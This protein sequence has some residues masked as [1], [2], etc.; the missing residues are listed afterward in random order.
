MSDIV[1]NAVTTPPQRPVLTVSTSVDARGRNHARRTSRSDCAVVHVASGAETGAAVRFREDHRELAARGVGVED[2]ALVDDPVV[3][4]G[5]S[6]EVGRVREDARQI[7]EGVLRRS[8]E[9][10]RND[11]LCHDRDWITS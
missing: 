9:T 6:I 7:R 5:I 8:S 4:G 11:W 2:A 1:M 10:V 3:F